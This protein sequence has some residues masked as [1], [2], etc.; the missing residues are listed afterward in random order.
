MTWA[1]LFVVPLNY[2]L[3]ESDCHFRTGEEL[4]RMLNGRDLV[5]LIDGLNEISKHELLKVLNVLDTSPARAHVVL[6][7]R[8]R[9]YPTE[10]SN[11]AVYDIPPLS[12]P[13]EVQGFLTNMLAP[14]QTRQIVSS[15]ILQVCEHNRVLR[16]LA[17]NP[18]MLSQLFQVARKG[19]PLPDDRTSLLELVA[20]NMVRDQPLDQVMVATLLSDLADE[21][22]FEREIL[23][24]SVEAIVSRPRSSVNDPERLTNMLARLIDVRL[25]VRSSKPSHP[26]QRELQR[27][28]EIGFHHQVFQEYFAGVHLYK[29]QLRSGTVGSARSAIRRRAKSRWNWQAICTAFVLLTRDGEQPARQITDWLVRK[30]PNLAALILSEIPESIASLDYSLQFNERLVKRLKRKVVFWALWIPHCYNWLPALLIGVM[31]SAIWSVRRVADPAGLSANMLYPGKG[32]PALVALALLLPT[33]YMILLTAVYKWLDDMLFDRL[34]HPSLASLELLRFRGGRET[35]RDL[36]MRAVANPFISERMKSWIVSS[37]MIP[38]VDVHERHTLEWIRGLP[39]TRKDITDD[40]VALLFDRLHD[41]ATNE[42]ERLLVVEALTAALR[43]L[44][45]DE[46][47]H[48]KIRDGLR[49]YLKHGAKGRVRRRVAAALETDERAASLWRH[50]IHRQ[51]RD[52]AIWIF[53]G[54]AIAFVCATYFSLPRMLEF[55]SGALVVVGALH[56]IIGVIQHLY[57]RT[58]IESEKQ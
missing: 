9:E 18:Y 30:R 7:S 6:T 22:Q 31:L 10:Y 23:K 25:L 13:N 52:P 51:W 42:T 47:I 41:E 21:M 48:I 50:V 28:D 33:T 40:W 1:D 32:L 5:M 37:P 27:N 43:I 53:I 3:K 11:Y 34:V 2:T 35:L 45:S 15:R 12:F 39:E 24:L 57:P 17:T 4:A 8:I 58:E 20:D 55:I 14:P 54:G 56:S 16:Q 46:A 29:H 26:D 38:L 44:G 19:L 49:N 36:R